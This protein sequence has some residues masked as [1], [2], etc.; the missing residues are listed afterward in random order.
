VQDYGHGT[1]GTDPVSFA[2]RA[3]LRFLQHLRKIAATNGKTK[4]MKLNAEKAPFFVG[5]LAVCFGSPEFSLCRPVTLRVCRFEC[6][7]P[8]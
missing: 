6:C 7:P 1:S 2:N 3:N 8:L 4:F 5:K